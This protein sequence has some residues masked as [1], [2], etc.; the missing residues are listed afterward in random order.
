MESKSKCS[1]DD[2]FMN[3]AFNYIK[4][5]TYSAVPFIVVLSLNVAVIW[6]TVRA[7]PDLRRSVGGVEM[8]PLDRQRSGSGC[9]QRSTVFGDS[10]STG[11]GS[12]R[13]PAISG[14]QGNGTRTSI[15]A[16]Q[17]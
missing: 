11:S 17:V 12:L 5:A 13:V 4:F 16:S 8:L 15:T 9:T 10:T 3:V 14:S 6:R 1:V 7:S 2:W